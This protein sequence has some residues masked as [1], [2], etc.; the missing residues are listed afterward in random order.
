[1]DVGGLFGVFVDV[2]IIVAAA[3]VGYTII[4]GKKKGSAWWT[5]KMKETI[6]QNRTAYENYYKMSEDIKNLRRTECKHWKRRAQETV[7]VKGRVF[8]CT[9]TYVLLLC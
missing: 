5:D 1:M 3:V 9:M 6:D 7:R 8:Y 4:R 2:V